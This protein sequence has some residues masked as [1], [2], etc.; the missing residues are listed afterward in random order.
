V[1][2]NDQQDEPMAD[3]KR[4]AKTIHSKLSKG[5]DIMARANEH[6]SR[7][8]NIPNSASSSNKKESSKDS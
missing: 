2:Y 1:V 3:G 5:E 6:M 7:K 4:S 8:T